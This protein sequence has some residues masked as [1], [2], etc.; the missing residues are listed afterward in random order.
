MHR[1][2]LLSILAAYDRNWS[3]P[4]L[5][6]IWDAFG[7]GA[8]H[9][10]V[11]RFRDFVRR[12]PDCFERSHP[13]GH[14][15][16]AALVVNADLS[17][18][19]LTHHRKLDIW[20]QLGGHADGH[21]VMHEVAMKEAEEESG[22]RRLSFLTCG[23]L[24][25]AE[26]PLPFDLDVHAIPAHRADPPHF[27]YDVRYLVESADEAYVVSD[28]SHDLRWLTLDEARALT[29]EVST[30]RMFDKLEMIRGLR[31]GI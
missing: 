18:V 31:A 20:I 26:D 22:L 25:H 29:D 27:H 8:E 23:P 7:A 28:E 14:L 30:R 5:S 16:G 4:R 13:H 21:T 10:V 12:T 3:A 11:E 19:L 9:A 1:A 15:T 6:Q 17:R 24:L 2:H